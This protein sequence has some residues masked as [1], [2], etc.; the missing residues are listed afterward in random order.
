[1]ATAT[2]EKVRIPRAQAVN[3]LMYCG[4]K[5][6]NKWTNE[7]CNEKLAL[8]KDVAPEG[9]PT[10]EGVASTLVKVLAATEDGLAFDVYSE[11]GDGTP[12]AGIGT[13]A[14]RVLSDEEKAVHDK[15]KAQAEKL[16]EEEKA[17]IK[18]IRDKAKAEKAALK[19][20]AKGTTVRAAKVSGLDGVNPCRS[21]MYIAAQVI[22]K[23][24]LKAGC[25]DAII[26][27]VD[28]LCDKPN[29]RQTGFCVSNAWHALNGYLKE[30]PVGDAPAETETKTESAS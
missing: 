16:K 9:T 20:A 21:R 28:A 4:L 11:E 23:H 22:A 1:M 6:A 25:T 10:D 17:A 5:L 8:V 15:I 30:Y 18:A 12:A 24:G 29:R 14:P 3:L 27:E 13:K 26:D 7:R 19:A 2:A